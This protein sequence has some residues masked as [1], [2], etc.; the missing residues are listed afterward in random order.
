MTRKKDGMYQKARERLAVA[1]ETTGSRVKTEVK[2]EHM[3]LLEG[4]KRELM[5]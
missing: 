1:A 5:G 4:S 3:N 2:P